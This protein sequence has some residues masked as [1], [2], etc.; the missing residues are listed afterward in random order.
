[1]TYPG[2]TKLSPSPAQLNGAPTVVGQ[3]AAT[4]K[5]IYD[6]SLTFEGLSKA[7]WRRRFDI[8]DGSS[9][10]AIWQYVVLDHSA[11]V[12]KQSGDT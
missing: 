6:F 12:E 4:L 1:M 7:N 11:A 5:G 9:C 3:H 8:G 10:I 2:R